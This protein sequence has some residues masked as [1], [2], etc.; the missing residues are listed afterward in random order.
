[1]RK[2]KIIDAYLAPM[3]AVT[4]RKVRGPLGFAARVERTDGG[5]DVCPNMG[6]GDDIARLREHAEREA[7][8]RNDAKS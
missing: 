3:P 2:R 5:I 7:E 1:M 4:T 6:N 8:K